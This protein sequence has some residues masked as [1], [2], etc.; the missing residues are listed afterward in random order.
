[1]RGA[2]GGS[3]RSRVVFE[4]LHYRFI[5]GFLKNKGERFIAYASEVPFLRKD[6]TTRTPPPPSHHLQMGGRVKKRSRGIIPASGL[7][8]NIQRNWKR[9]DGEGNSVE[10]R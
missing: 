2:V 8:E 1:M 10:E 3:F 4:K 9:E 5:G 6:C 7:F